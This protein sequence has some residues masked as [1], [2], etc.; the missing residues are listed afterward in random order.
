MERTN[1]LWKPRG[2]LQILDLCLDFFLFKFDDIED[3]KRVTYQG[4]WF[5]GGHF[6]AI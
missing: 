5:I 3:L 4:P 6:Q 1:L 2:N